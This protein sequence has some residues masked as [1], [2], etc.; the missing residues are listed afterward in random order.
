[1]RYCLP[2]PYEELSHTA[3]VGLEARGA[4]AAEACA[5]V[6]LAMAQLQAGGGPV[7]PREERAIEARGEDRASLLVDFCRQVL[8]R[9][10]SERL[11]LAAVELEEIGETRARA[12]A[13]FGPFDPERHGEGVDLKAVTYARAA[14]EPSGDGWRATLI[15]DI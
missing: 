11:L 14:L 9:F 12:R 7:E 2:S 10:Y 3:D 1:M 6:A 5:R 4:D 8:A 13:W 15:F